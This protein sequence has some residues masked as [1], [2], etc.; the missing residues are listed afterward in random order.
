MLP[1]LLQGSSLDRDRQPTPWP[2]T[3]HA[4]P[5]K[6]STKNSKFWWLPVQWDKLQGILLHVWQ[7]REAG[8]LVLAR[9]CVQLQVWGWLISGTSQ[10]TCGPFQLAAEPKD[11]HCFSC[12]RISNNCIDPVPSMVREIVIREAK[13]RE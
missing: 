12:N 7:L 11:V 4:G 6:T 9:P 3:L 13:A 5:A 2:E 1:G 8:Q 10:S